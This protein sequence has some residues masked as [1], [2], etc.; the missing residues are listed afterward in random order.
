[1]AIYTD[2]G[3]LVYRIGV[4]NHMYDT[5]EYINDNCITATAVVIPYGMNLKTSWSWLLLYAALDTR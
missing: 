4:H 3:V 5:L 1:M 2:Y